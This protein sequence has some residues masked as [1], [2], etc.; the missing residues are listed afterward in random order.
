MPKRIYRKNFLEKLPAGSKLVALPSKWGNPYT[1]PEDGDRPTV[2][3][4]YRLWI[5]SQP[6]MIERARRELRGLD[7]ACYCTLDELCHADILLEIANSGEVT[8]QVE[9]I[10]KKQERR[11][12]IAR[13]AIQAGDLMTE[14]GHDRMPIELMSGDYQDWID[15]SSMR[16]KWI[17]SLGAAGVTLRQ[18]NSYAW[19]AVKNGLLVFD[20]GPGITCG[21]SGCGELIKPV[22]FDERVARFLNPDE[23]KPKR[24]KKHKPQQ[25][26]LFA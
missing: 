3:G 14:S 7:L 20:K 21:L 4:K 19:A 26:G 2:V 24:K 10:K 8:A 1:I 23:V 16:E 6:E 18:F 11:E 25:P 13:Q 17:V 5:E 22:D 12:A 15:E 9:P